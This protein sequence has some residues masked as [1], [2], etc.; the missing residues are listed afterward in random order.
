MGMVRCNKGHFYDNTKF[1]Q[2]PHCGIFFGEDD[3]KTMAMSMDLSSVSSGI[4]RVEDDEKTVAMMPQGIKIE[5]ENNKSC[6]VDEEDKT[7]SLYAEKTGSD[8]IT[9]WLVC[10]TGAERGRDYKLHQGFNRVGR[11]YQLDIAVMDDS[12]ISREAA[13]AVVYDDKSN[14]FFAVQQ[15]SGTA[16]L[17]GKTLEGAMPLKTGDILYT[18]NSEFEFVAFCREGR[19]WN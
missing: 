18:G 19:T 16:Y 5:K 8:F 17:N 3:E 11:D 1:S 2:C 9:G 6:V 4:N 14:Q 7:V 13:F 10:I 12:A 15:S